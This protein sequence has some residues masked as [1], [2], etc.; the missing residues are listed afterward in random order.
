MSADELRAPDELRARLRDAVR[1]NIDPAWLPGLEPIVDRILAVL[2][3][4]DGG[5]AF[6]PG[7]ARRGLDLLLASAP[8]L[9]LV[10]GRRRD[11]DV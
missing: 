10:D 5:G 4:R 1:G 2:A 11:V 3:E 6:A 7:I 9:E 8:H